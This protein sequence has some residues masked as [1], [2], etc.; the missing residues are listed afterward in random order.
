MTAFERGKSFGN[1]VTIA[2]AEYKDLQEILQLQY[3]AYQTEAALFAEKSIPPLTQTLDEV[4]SEYDDGIILKMVA[5][6]KI[7]GSVRAAEKN[8][9]IYIGKLMVHPSFRRNG[10]GRKLLTEMER[11]YPGRK[12]RLFT[13]TRSIG[14][15]RLYKSLGYRIYDQKRV[16]DELEFVYL[17]KS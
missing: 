8:G 15:I 10:Y 1:D 7:I 3:L 5:G 11:S 4:I 2:K 6:N 9:K 14:N 12:Y 16:S 17:E 13:S